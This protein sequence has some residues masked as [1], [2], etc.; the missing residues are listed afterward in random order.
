[1]ANRFPF[2]EDFRFQSREF[3]GLRPRYIFIG[4]CARMASPQVIEPR[5]GTETI[6]PTAR[7]ADDAGRRRSQAS[8]EDRRAPALARASRLPRD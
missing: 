6:R 3:H 5:S 2:E 7:P 1:M 4:S 8:R